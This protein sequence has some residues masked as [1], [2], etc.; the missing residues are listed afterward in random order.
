MKTR[1]AIAALF[2]IVLVDVAVAVSMPGVWL[3]PAALAGWFLADLMSGVVHMVMDYRPSPPDVGLDR[4]YAYEGSRE[5]GEYLAM[6]RAAFARLTPIQRI[7]YDFKNHHPRPDALGRRPMLTQVGATVS[8]TTLPFALVANG[9]LALAGWSAPA[10]A[11][12]ASFLIGA[13]FAQYFH[14]TLHRA[15]NPWPV[16]LMRRLRLLMRPEDHRHHHDTLAQDFSTINGWSN[17]ILNAVFR[18]AHRYGWL[19]DEGLVPR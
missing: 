6:R 5:S 2:L 7:T 17:P 14:G 3:V 13:T 1:A 8:F 19:R 16:L 10:A 9:A 11:M 4:L 15:A 18:L 12:L